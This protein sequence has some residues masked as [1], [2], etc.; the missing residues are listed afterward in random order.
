ME[1]RIA[2][3]VNDNRQYLPW[4]QI[5]APYLPLDLFSRNEGYQYGNWVFWEYL[6]TLYGNNI[7]LKAWKQAGTLKA[8]GGKNSITALQ[9]VLKKKG[10]L[11][12]VYAKV[13]RRQ[14]HP[15]RQLPRGRGVP[16][17]QGPRQARR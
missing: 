1:E 15:G 11:T 7:V 3:A 4:S 13:R 16:D 6:S 17:P 12:K 8:D 5:Y 14:P 9:K 2:T 10:G